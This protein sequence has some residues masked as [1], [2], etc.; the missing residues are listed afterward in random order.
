MLGFAW[1]ESDTVTLFEL[2]DTAALFYHD[3]LR[4]GLEGMALGANVNLQFLFGGTGF[5]AVAASADDFYFL[6][7]RMNALF[8]L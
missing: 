7:L 5:E 6:I 4:T 1:L 2:V 3:A 8:H